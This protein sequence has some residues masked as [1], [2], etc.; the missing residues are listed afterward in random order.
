MSSASSLSLV[1]PVYLN[2]ASVPQLLAELSRLA[3]QLGTGFEVVFVVDGSPDRSAEVLRASLPGQPYA[4]QLLCLSRNF[5]SFAAIR[6]GLETAGNPLAAVMAADLQEPPELILEL[7]RRV[8]DDG[9]D[10]AVGVREGRADPFI[11]RMTASLFWRIYRG[12]AQREMP[13]GGVDVFAC[14]LPVRRHL[15]ALTENNTSL[16]GLLF[17]LGFRRAE[18]PYKRQVRRYGRSAWS[19]ARK[20]RYLLDSLFAFTDL[21]LRLI[22]LAGGL[23]MTLALG[24]GALVIWSRL[25]GRIPIPGYAATVLVVMFFGGLNALSLGLVGEYIWRAFENTKQR[26]TY[27]IA[28]RSSFPAAAQA[29]GSRS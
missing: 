28:H 21:P 8:R 2:E 27:V 14:T 1:I 4:S 13:V 29:G 5:G 20:F 12:L 25:T 26:P 16:V 23:S 7:V 17:W 19:V 11:S 9:F 6:A 3:P 10:V 18:V 15:L 22:S 24:L